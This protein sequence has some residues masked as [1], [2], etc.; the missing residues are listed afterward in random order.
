MIYV[1]NLSTLHRSARIIS[2]LLLAS[3]AWHY[4]QTPV[5]IIFGLSALVMGVTGIFGYC[6]V[7]KITGKQ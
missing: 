7:C 3:C 4:G 1:K 6:P 5:G 2:T